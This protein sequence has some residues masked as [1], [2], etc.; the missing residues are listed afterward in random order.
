[1]FF[2][3]RDDR[4]YYYRINSDSS[5]SNILQGFWL[6]GGAMRVC[7]LSDLMSDSGVKKGVPYELP[8][9]QVISAF[10]H[11][12]VDIEKYALYEYKSLSIKF[13]WQKK[14]GK[15]ILTFLE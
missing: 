8:K 10:K 4:D 7:E 13:E 2:G 6:L 15:V 9:E 11:L 14:E 5:N 3:G 1:M 12:G